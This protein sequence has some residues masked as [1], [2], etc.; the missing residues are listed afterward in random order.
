MY[1]CGGRWGDDTRDQMLQAEGLDDLITP[2]RGKRADVGSGVS[3]LR[4]RWGSAIDTGYVAIPSALLTYFAELKITPT[5]FLVLLELLSHWWKAEAKPFPRVTTIARRLGMTA[6]TVQ[7]ALN[8]L[9]AAGLLSWERVQV[10]DGRIMWHAQRGV[11]ASRRIYDMSPLVDRATRL[12]EA[13]R[14]FLEI[15]G[16]GVRPGHSHGTPQAGGA[17]VQSQP[18]A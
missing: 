1:C 3:S 14:R 12:S 2:E 5:Q 4:S 9:R 10:L 7:R 13:R 11:G 18:P 8:G 17:G 6:R 15:G 16:M